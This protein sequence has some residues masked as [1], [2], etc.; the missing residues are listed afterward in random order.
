M[1]QIIFR[2]LIHLSKHGT[3]ELCRE[4]KTSGFNS[5]NTGCKC[6]HLFK[7]FTVENLLFCYSINCPSHLFQFSQSFW[8]VFKFPHCAKKL[9]CSTT[10]HVAGNN[11]TPHVQNVRNII[12]QIYKS[13][14]SLKIVFKKEGNC[15]YLG[16]ISWSKRKLWEYPIFHIFHS[17]PIFGTNRNDLISISKFLIPLGEREY[18]NTTGEILNTLEIHGNFQFWSVALHQM[19]SF[20]KSIPTLYQKQD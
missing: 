5:A 3:L 9:C 4:T 16:I 10:I 12:K 17:M 20:P 1:L 19:C 8:L 6:S 13:L 11:K 15:S 2:K 18:V 7:L 14:I